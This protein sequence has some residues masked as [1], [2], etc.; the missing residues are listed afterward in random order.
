M[1]EVTYIA[2]AERPRMD[3]RQ[4]ESLCM[5]LGTKGAEDAVC[6]AMEQLGQQL[7]QA[8]QFAFDG[9]QLKL[10]DTLA[11]LRTTAEHIGLCGLAHVARD[12]MTCVEFGDGVAQAATLARLGRI[13]ERSLAALWD[14]QDMSI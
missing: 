11:N 14:L 3:A 5:E 1:G 13:G 2:P 4:I 9:E 12:V 7:H 8:H 10:Y 6:R